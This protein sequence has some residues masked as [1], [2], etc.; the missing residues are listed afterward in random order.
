MGIGIVIILGVLLSGCCCCSN[1]PTGVS[2]P[3]VGPTDQYTPTDAYAP[4]YSPTDQPFDTRISTEG[5]A[6]GDPQIS[7][8]WNNIN[9]LDLHCTT[10]SGQDIYYDNKQADNGVLDV[11]MNADEDSLSSAPVE[12]IVWQ[13]GT[14]PHGHYTVS[15]VYYANHGG[16]DSN[17][18]TVRVIKNGQT[19]TFHGT[20]SQ[21]DDSQTVYEFD[22]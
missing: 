6:S 3:I 11:D 17:D 14:A 12:N 8:I 15:V 20:I 2:N 16:P 7:L 4:T 18:Y 22:L 13:P 5:G 9:D 1:I 10:P 21:V 19:Q